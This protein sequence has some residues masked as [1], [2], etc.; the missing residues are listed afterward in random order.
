MQISDT[1]MYRYYELLTDYH[2]GGDCG[3][4]GADREE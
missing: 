2:D 4:A 1:L 3:D